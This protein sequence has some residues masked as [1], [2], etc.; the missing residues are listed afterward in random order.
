[1]HMPVPLFAAHQDPDTDVWLCSDELPWM[2][3]WDEST[4]AVDLM[5]PLAMRERMPS[6]QEFLEL[7]THPENQS[8]LAEDFDLLATEEN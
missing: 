5:E 8:E 6:Q 7:E 1:M 2:D 3:D 4:A